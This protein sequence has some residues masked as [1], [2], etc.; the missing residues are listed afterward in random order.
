[1]FDGTKCGRK[2]L[3]G[4]VISLWTVDE[5]QLISIT[6]V[7]IHWNF[8]NISDL[9]L[10]CM[11]AWCEKNAFKPFNIYWSWNPKIENSQYKQTKRNSSKCLCS[12]FYIFAACQSYQRA[13]IYSFILLKGYKTRP[14]CLQILQTKLTHSLQSCMSDRCRTLN[15]FSIIFLD[16]VWGCKWSWSMAQK[17]VCADW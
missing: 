8:T 17:M 2:R 5:L 12:L 6:T 13:D 7:W 16:N 3:F 11:D 14:L 10:T 9:Y 4:K 1:M 15:V